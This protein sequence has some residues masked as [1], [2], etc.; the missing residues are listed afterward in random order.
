MR[1]EMCEQQKFVHTIHGPKILS[2][3]NQVSILCLHSQRIRTTNERD[4]APLSHLID[5]LRHQSVSTKKFIIC[6]NS[7][8]S[9]NNWL[10]L[11]P[12]RIF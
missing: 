7:S 8:I 10:M 6:R 3:L 4:A 2:N 11:F 9:L 12:K 1:T 5:F